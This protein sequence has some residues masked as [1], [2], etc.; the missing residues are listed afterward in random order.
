MNELSTNIRLVNFPTGH[1]RV[2]EIRDGSE[3]TRVKKN[4]DPWDNIRKVGGEE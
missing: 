3:A 4:R 2:L 1:L